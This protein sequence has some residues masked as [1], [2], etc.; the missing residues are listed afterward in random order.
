MLDIAG[1]IA[2]L[3]VGDAVERDPTLLGDIY[4]RAL[5]AM[6]PVAPVSIRVH[7]EDRAA[8]GIDGP[9]RRR[10]FEVIDDPG[11][12]RGG[13]VVAWER[14]EVDASLAALRAALREAAGGTG[15]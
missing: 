8:S 6:G 14:A 12:G 9:A 2:E 13:C 3:L 7:P 1:R 4:D 5:S 15:E 10:D 11:V